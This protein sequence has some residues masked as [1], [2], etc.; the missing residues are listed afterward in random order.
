MN[1]DEIVERYR[2]ANEGDR[3]T[4]FFAHRDLRRAFSEIDGEPPD[5]P[6]RGDCPV[7]ISERESGWNDRLRFADRGL[8]CESDNPW[9]R[10]TRE[11]SRSMKSLTRFVAFDVH[12]ET[13][14]V[15]VAEPDGS[16][17]AL[18]IHPNRLESIRKVVKRLGPPE[19]LRA[20]YEAGPCGYVLYWQLAELGVRCDVIAPTLI[21]VKSGDRVKTDR[22]DAE[23][24]ARCFRNGDLTPVWVPDAAHEALRDLVRARLCAKIDETRARNRLTKLLLRHGHR[25]PERAKGWGFVRM[26]WLNSM[27]FAEGAL[28]AAFIDYRAEVEHLGARIDRLELAIDVAV[29][30][31]PAAL[32]AFY[33]ALQALR[34]VAKV[35]AATIVA[36]V[37]DISRFKKARELMAYSGAVPS[38][39]SSGAS[40]RRGAITKTGNVHLRRVVIEAGIAYRHRP[41]MGAALRKRSATQTTAIRDIAWKA[42]HRLHNRYCRLVGRGKSKQKAVTAVSRELLGFIWAIGQEVLRAPSTA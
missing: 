14:A 30:A 20:C 28:E 32:R 15:A 34:G 12:A 17:K 18:G 35:T 13:V 31:A 40:I 4:L 37:G 19:R 24:L 2:F 36:E 1:L 16:I 5:T 27:H 25:P 21:P 42:Q 29:A 39:H 11:R 22:R 6:R 33:D 38:E 7:P 26:R 8:R 23:R 41:Q 9:R 10:A 3:M